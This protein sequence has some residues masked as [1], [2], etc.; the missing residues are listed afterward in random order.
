[1]RKFKTPVALIIFNRPDRTRK[2]L[3]ILSTVQPKEI[4]IIADGPR[5]TVPGEKE[6]CEQTRKIVKNINWKCKLYTNFSEENLGCGERPATGISWIFK[7]VVLAIILE[8]DFVPHPSFFPFCEEL[9]NR[10]KDDERIMMI[11]GNNFQFGQKRTEYSYYFS[12]FTHIW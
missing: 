10:Y 5:K 8:D 12:I 11:S 6:I 2:L 3:S 7:H 4:F 1:M 9:L